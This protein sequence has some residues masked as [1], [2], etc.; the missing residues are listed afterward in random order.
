MLQISG[1]K[2]KEEEGET[3][4]RNAEVSGWFPLV[5]IRSGAATRVENSPKEHPKRSG[6]IEKH[7]H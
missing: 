3:E 6:N 1:L 5:K 7:H 2:K 4:W